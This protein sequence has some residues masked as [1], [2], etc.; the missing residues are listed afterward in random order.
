[1]KVL[2]IDP[3]NEESA[4]CVIDVK[5]LR[6]VDFGKIENEELRHYIRQYQFSEEDRAA[7]EMIASYGM[8]V[9]AEVF[10]TAR[11]IGR[12]EECL[13][14]LLNEP[15]TLIYRMQEKMHICH[16]SKAKD[17]NIRIALIDRFAQHDKKAGKGTKKNP[18]WFYG[19][20]ADVWAAYAV[21]ITYIETVLMDGKE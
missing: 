21:G 17:T 6:P 2:A 4:Y 7:V 5:T 20:A 18:D 19:F 1:M 11:W 13:L 14:R 15:P 10:D 16:N 12:Y 8:G 3:G 9:G